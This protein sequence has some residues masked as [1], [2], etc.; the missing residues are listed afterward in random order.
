MPSNSAR[1]TSSEYSRQV[2][3]GVEGLFAVPQVVL[4][5]QRDVFARGAE[6]RDR[7]RAFLRGGCRKS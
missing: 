4:R 2:A 7:G 5:A 1:V 3:Q 6:I